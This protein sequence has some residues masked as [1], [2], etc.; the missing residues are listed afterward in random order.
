M[1][2]WRQILEEAARLRHSGQFD[3]ARELIKQFK[4]ADSLEQRSKQVIVWAHEPFWWRVI[5]GRRCRLR[6]RDAQ[7]VA[8]IRRLWKDEHFIS[9]FNRFAVRLPASDVGLANLLS[10]EYASIVT[11]SNSI[12]WAVETKGGVQAGVLSFTNFSI[13]NRRAETLIGITEFPY[14]GIS[15]EAM[16]LAVEFGF[17]SMGLH[18]IY[19]LIYSDNEISLRNTL[20]LGFEVEGRLREHVVDPKTKQPLDLIQTGLL[21]SDLTKLVFSRLGRRLLGRELTC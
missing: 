3:Q 6:R 1:A 5:E 10:R 11:E 7:D 21:R 15:V 2:S 20:H 4:P 14:S 8:F 13:P 17:G 12:H 16:L 9:A 18:K 19:S